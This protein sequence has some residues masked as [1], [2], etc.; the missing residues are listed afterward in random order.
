[1]AADGPDSVVAIVRAYPARIR[2]RAARTDWRVTRRLL[3]VTTLVHAVQTAV[4]VELR[5]PVA[6][7]TAALFL[8]RPAVAWPLSTFL[9][10]DATHFLG[11]A[12]LLVATGIEA[13]RHLSTR[14]YLA[15]FVAAAVATPLVGL[16]A[17][18]PFVDGPVAVYGISGFVFA[19]ATCLLV[20]FSLAH[21]AALATAEGVDPRRHPLEGFAVLLGV[22]ALLLVAFDVGTALLS[23]GRGVN[24][25][26]LGGVLVGLG[27]GVVRGVACSTPV[28]PSAE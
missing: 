20:H 3:L 19:L 7:V 13:Q 5:V 21:D 8:E 28:W 18:R 10:R 23:G 22:S 11:N 24:G 16:A 9:H 2:A 25:G 17:R 12:V 6:G 27:A 14:Q 15:L 26:H 4:A 1:M